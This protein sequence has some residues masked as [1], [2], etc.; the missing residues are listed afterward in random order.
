M[1]L[2][3]NVRF[4]P[5]GRHT[6]RRLRSHRSLLSCIVTV[7]MAM[8]F[9]VPARCVDSSQPRPNILFIAVD[10]LR[11][12]IGCYGDSTALTPN[13]D[14][15]A[16]R[17]TTFT[18]AYCQQAVCSPSRLSL[19]TGRR[20]DT[21]RVWDLGTHFR[22]ALP[23]VVT[24]PQFFRQAGYHTQSIGKIFH[25]NGKPAKD[26]ISWSESP[27]HDVVRDPK[28]RYASQQNLSGAGLKR[29]SFESADVPD[30]AYADGLA[31]RAALKY[32]R[33]RSAREE[34]F[35]LAVGFRKPHLPFCAPK[36][37]WDLYDAP[38]IPMPKHPQHPESAPELAT[39]S[40][41]ELEGYRDVPEDGHLTQSHVRRLRHG[42]FACVSY[43][44]A[45]IGRVLNELR[46][47]SLHENTVVV[48]W[49]DHGFHLGEQ[50]LWTKAN[51][52]ELATRVPLIIACPSG[53]NAQRSPDTPTPSLFRQ[54]SV[55][56]RLVELVDLYPTLVDV[57][58][59]PIPS[60]LEG[61]NMVPLL[62]DPSLAWKNAA[63]SQFPRATTGHRH[64]RH[65]D[66]MG[67]AVRTERYRYVEWQDWTT[68]TVI[69][70]ELYDHDVDAEE[71][72][73]IANAPKYAD[74]QKQL[75]ETLTA[76][77]KAA[78]PSPTSD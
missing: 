20:P 75:S 73:N 62:K 33:Q 29:D 35:F 17:G 13:L 38:S 28:L 52:Y 8:L 67:Y 16:S 50:G 36:R 56:D 42:Y 64:R 1:K 6:L 72:T 15:L 14:R 48:V 51:N 27:I 21:T 46:T 32:L 9:A 39:R 74:V 68:K 31:C 22:Q 26:D 63:F 76:G 70:S 12:T 43:I 78:R 40:W 19:L 23:D 65:G 47:Q 69:A 41:R 37:Y 30:D 53:A 58:G 34:P 44:D 60:G 10:D 54:D 24:L 49:G 2:L 57:C 45:L 7:A 4:P 66:I 77:W 18:R 61:T 3:S 71:M 25:G 11:P 5:H 59:F 55:C